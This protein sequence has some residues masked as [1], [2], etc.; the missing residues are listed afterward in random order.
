MGRNRSAANLAVEVSH[1]DKRKHT[2]ND[3]RKRPK[4]GLRL[5]Y[6]WPRRAAQHLARCPEPKRFFKQP[7]RP[8]LEELGQRTAFTNR[9]KRRIRDAKTTIVI[10]AATESTSSVRF[11]F[12]FLDFGCA[13]H[14]STLHPAQSQNAFSNKP[15]R[16][17]RSFEVPPI[18]AI[19]ASYMTEAIEGAKK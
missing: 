18:K 1:K 8:P 10:I 2:G 13:L 17:P 4:F 9:A 7:M 19:D 3:I 15:M 11:I 14:P 12:G 5:G 16:P 6:F